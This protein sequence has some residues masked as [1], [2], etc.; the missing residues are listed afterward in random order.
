MSP[1]PLIR[2]HLRALL[3]ASK[4]VLPRPYCGHESP[5]DLIS[6][7]DPDAI[8]LGWDLGSAFLISLIDS[9]ISLD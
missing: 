4:A 3:C 7:A 2:M 1:L 5:G 6:N 8:G 9:T